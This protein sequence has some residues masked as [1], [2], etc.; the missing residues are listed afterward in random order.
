MSANSVKSHESQGMASLLER[1]P[2]RATLVALTVILACGTLLTGWTV[3]RADRILR[4]DLLQQARLVSEG[5][6]LE[7]LKALSGTT[8]DLD[9][10]VYLLLKEQLA[11]IKETLPKCRFLY[12]IGRKPDGRVFFFVDNEPVGSEDESPAGQIYEEV[13]PEYLRAFVTREAVV[14]GPIADRWGTWVS[15]LVPLIDPKADGLVAML[16]MDVNAHCWNQQL[17]R[18]AVPPVLV[19]LALAVVTLVGSRLLAL[20][21]LTPSMPGCWTRYQEAAFAAVVGLILTLFF[22]WTTNESESRN[23]AL[24]FRS[25]AVS[26]TAA[27]AEAFRDLQDIELEGLA[28]F[29]AGSE[30]VATAEFQQYA[31]FLSKSQLVRAWEWIAA[32]PSAEKVRFEKYARQ[33]GRATFEI[34]QKDGAGNRMPVTDREVY[35]PVFQVLPVADNDRLVGYDLGSEPLRKAALDAAARTGLTTATDPIGLVPATDDQKTMQVCRSIYDMSEPK[36][37]RGFAV[38]I[39]GPE[40]AAEGAD[41]DHLVAIEL[42]LLRRGGPPQLLGRS[43]QEDAPPG[44]DLAVTRPVLAFGKA[45]AVTAHPG[46]QFESRH[47]AS[48]GWLALLIGIL[49]TAAISL[50]IGAILYR[51]EAL[52]QL[53]QDRTASLMES[54]EHLSA[55]LRS[56]GDGVISCDSGGNITGLN[57]AAEVMTGWYAEEAMGNPLDQVFQITDAVTHQSASVVVHHVLATGKA[58]CLADGTMLIARDGTERLIADSC[59]PIRDSAGSIDGAV[60]VFRDVTTEHRMRQELRQREERFRSLV[61]GSPNW[62]MLFDVDGRFVVNNQSGLRAMGWT[63]DDV[64]GKRFVEVWPESTRPI[65]EDAVKRVLQGEDVPFEAEGIRHDG[66]SVTWWVVLSPIQQE[67]DAVDHFVGIATDIT[68]RKRAEEAVRNSKERFGPAC[69]A[70]PHGRLGDR[71]ARTTIP[72]SATFAETVLGYAATELVGRKH[73]FDLC[74]DDERKAFKESRLRGL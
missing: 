14:E 65:V 69:P 33:A 49:L 45:F 63:M 16:G 67:D 48:A 64:L 3:R 21:S 60:L 26:R 2:A 41:Q 20:R 71:R 44:A 12:L 25:I 50:T 30:N 19:A 51:R 4:G 58:A 6:D 59:A 74:P 73:F 11:G 28:R 40:A 43:D 42:S 31:G 10:P 66:S 8:A 35:Y 36:H 53:I 24:S 34:W 18:A 57:T 47:P 1:R 68:Q 29:Y 55:T 46:R 72:T 61:E 9:S 70:K 13:S 22:A 54:R 7:N 62:V 52:E 27:I 32:V 15:A 23:R 38:A 17:A 39:L 5:I 56:I 37:L